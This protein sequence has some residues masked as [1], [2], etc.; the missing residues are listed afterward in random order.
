MC[1]I[2][3]CTVILIVPLAYY[4]LSKALNSCL[5]Q[6]ATRQM[7]FLYLEHQ[8]WDKEHGQLRDLNIFKDPTPLQHQQKVESQRSSNT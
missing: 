5:E 2:I 6:L 7:I 4:V 8:K 1:G 3:L